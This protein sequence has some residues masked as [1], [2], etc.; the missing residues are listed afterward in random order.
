MKTGKDNSN[1]LNEAIALSQRLEEYDSETAQT[2]QYLVGVIKEMD[3]V[4]TSLI[5]L[6]VRLM[7]S[8][9]HISKILNRVYM[10]MR[11]EQQ[12]IVDVWRKG[13]VL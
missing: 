12:N 13:K 1:R 6:V 5:S 8:N 11:R 9:D 2:I 4:Q 7:R 3:K 10:T